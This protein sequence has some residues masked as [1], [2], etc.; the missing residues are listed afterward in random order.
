MR[1]G[2]EL[3]HSSGCLISHRTMHTLLR[4]IVQVLYCRNLP[5]AYLLKSDHDHCLFGFRAHLSISIRT[6]QLDQ[7]HTAGEAP[8]GADDG[9]VESNPNIAVVNPT[10]DDFGGPTTPAAREP[11]R[12]VRRDLPSSE[13]KPDEG[14]SKRASHKASYQP[15]SSP[16]LV[17]QTAAPHALPSSSLVPIHLH[18][19]NVLSV[20]TTHTPFPSRPR[21][22]RKN[23]MQ[24]WL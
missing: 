11:V 16:T 6:K 4:H 21:H 15:Y 14:L 19:C 8:A 17:L 7:A 9:I 13:G 3:A 24:P 1:F 20:K 5:T 2:R 10:T 23:R 12:R 22:H 18:T